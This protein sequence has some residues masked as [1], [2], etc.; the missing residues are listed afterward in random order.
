MED[1]DVYKTNAVLILALLAFF[2][3]FLIRHDKLIYELLYTAIALSVIQLLFFKLS[4][5]IAY[6]WMQFGKALGFINSKLIL[7]LV[8]ILI[9]LPIG[10]LKRKT[11]PNK[12]TNWKQ[13]DKIT[14]DFTKMG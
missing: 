7:S 1:K 10:L 2:S 11:I 9:L 6:G 14:V 12:D 5:Y 13:P 8:F 3:F 4:Y